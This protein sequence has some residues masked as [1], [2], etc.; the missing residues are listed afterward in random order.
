MATMRVPSFPRCLLAAAFYF[1]RPVEAEDKFDI[2]KQRVERIRNG[3]E[4]FP[5]TYNGV[6]LTIDN[7]TIEEYMYWGHVSG[8]NEE[9]ERTSRQSFLTLTTEGRVSSILQTM[10]QGL[11]TT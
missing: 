7:K 1:C 5:T 3:T 9:Y 8:M 6:A 4:V 2:C 10:T 11:L